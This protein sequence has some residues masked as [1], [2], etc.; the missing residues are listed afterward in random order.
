MA[1]SM[2]V[3]LSDERTLLDAFLDHH[4]R[5]A[6]GILD[7]LG[8]EQVRERLAVAG[9]L[10]EAAEGAEV[11]VTLLPAGRVHLLGRVLLRRGRLTRR[12]GRRRRRRPERRRRAAWRT[13][14]RWP[15]RW[16]CC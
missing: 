4:R 10:E 1:T 11:V 13:R 15:E 9:S 3:V 2:D 14:S 12:R 16:G 8:E 5:D 7:G 6:A